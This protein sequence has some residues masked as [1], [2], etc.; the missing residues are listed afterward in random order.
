VVLATTCGYLMFNEKISRTNFVG[1]LL[2][3]ASIILILL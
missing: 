1:I 3:V 2:A